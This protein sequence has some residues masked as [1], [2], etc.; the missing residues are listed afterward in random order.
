M[1]GWVEGHPQRFSL[2]SPFSCFLSS[3]QQPLVQC[4]GAGIDVVA[5][6]DTGSMKSFLSYAVV[7]KL[8]PRPVLVKNSPTCISITGQSLPVEGTT[9]LG[10]SFH[11]SISITYSSN[12]IVSSHIFPSLEYVLGWDFMTSHGFSVSV[13]P[14]GN[15]SLQGPNGPIPLTPHISKWDS[16]SPTSSESS[17]AGTSPCLLVQSATRN[18][19]TVSLKSSLCIV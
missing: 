19:I 9:Q 6:I 2:V 13:Y 3:S 1:K 7:E 4:S 12:F 14:E 16:L 17:S 18:P 11:S 8:Q 10:L 5:L 15:H